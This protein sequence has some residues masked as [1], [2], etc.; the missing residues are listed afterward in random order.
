VFLYE[1][2]V[3]SKKK[4]SGNGVLVPLMNRQGKCMGILEISRILEGD[5]NL[6]DE[7]SCI[8]LMNFCKFMVKLIRNKEKLMKIVKFFFS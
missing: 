6:D 5:F 4:V 7:Y 2:A 1:D 3:S 8:L